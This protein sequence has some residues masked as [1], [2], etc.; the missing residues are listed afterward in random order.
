MFLP[1]V[2]FSGRF[3]IEINKMETSIP[4]ISLHTEEEEEGLTLLSLE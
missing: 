3:K 1:V 2:R 4:G